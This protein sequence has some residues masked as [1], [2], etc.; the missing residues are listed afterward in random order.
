MY[1]YI[2]NVYITIS[3]IAQNPGCSDLNQ[4]GRATN[5]ISSTLYPFKHL[6][7]YIL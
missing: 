3:K 6:K 1:I 7:I 2:H 4:C 5:T